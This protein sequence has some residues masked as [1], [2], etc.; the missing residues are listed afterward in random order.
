MASPR[1][2]DL[3]EAVTR[4]GTYYNPSTDMIVI[5][6]DGASVDTDVFEDGTGEDS[7]WVLLA[8]E[9]PVDETSRDEAVERFESRYHPGATGAISADEDDEDEVDDIEPDPDPDDL[10]Y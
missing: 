2:F 5:V 8:D 6:D 1:R 7:E 9:V 10:D 3:E 4:P